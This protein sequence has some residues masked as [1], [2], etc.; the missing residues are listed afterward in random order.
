M[1]M[2]KWMSSLMQAKTTSLFIKV[3]V[4]DGV[5]VLFRL[6]IHNVRFV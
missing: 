2:R 5:I 1:N 3:D 4:V 6:L